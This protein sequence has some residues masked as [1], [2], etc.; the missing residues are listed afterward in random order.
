MH[1]TE[2]HGVSH[3]LDITENTCVFGNNRPCSASEFLVS[4]QQNENPSLAFAGGLRWQS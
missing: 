1:T 3:E 4:L 2:Y